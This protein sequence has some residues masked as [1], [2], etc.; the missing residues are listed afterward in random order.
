MA[1]Q[2]V[3]ICGIISID[4]VSFIDEVATT[5]GGE[6]IRSCIQCGICS[7]ACPVANEMEYPPRKIIAMIRADMRDEVLSS[8]SMWHCLSCYMCTVRCPRGVKPTDIAHTLEYLAYQHGFKVK[9]TTT[10]VLYRNFVNSIKANGRVHEVGIML[11]Y[12]MTTNPLA[13]LKVLPVGLNLL[14]HK[15]LPL[16][17]KKVK[18]REDLAKI[19]QKFKE[20]GARP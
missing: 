3:L 16:L 13:A 9:A 19:L 20:I 17:P 7:G 2:L 14:L 11:G 18:G 1:F 4:M 15:R 12:Y 10:P 6:H 5:P 8:S